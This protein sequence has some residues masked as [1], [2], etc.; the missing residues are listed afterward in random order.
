ME[1]ENNRFSF[2]SDLDDMVV[3]IGC[4]VSALACTEALG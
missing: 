4:T 2:G 1:K 3:Q